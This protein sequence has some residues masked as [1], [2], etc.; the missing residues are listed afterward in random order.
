[1]QVQ[2]KIYVKVNHIAYRLPCYDL[3]TGMGNHYELRH[4]FSVITKVLAETYAL[5]STAAD[6]HETPRKV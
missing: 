5:F 6:K 4:V 3:N 2:V 1:M